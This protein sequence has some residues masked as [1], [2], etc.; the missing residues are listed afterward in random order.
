MRYEIRLAGSGGQ[1]VIMAGLILAEAG[2][3]EGYH[4][5]QTQNYGP[6]VRGGTSIS[7]VILSDA[8]VD[9]PKTLGLDMLLAFDQR[10]CDEN[11]HDMKPEGLVLVDADLVEKVFWGKVVR[12]PFARWSQKKYKEQKFANVLA[13]GALASFCPWFSTGSLRKAIV[14]RVP[15][16]TV[17]SNLAALQE[18]NKLA[19]GL[20]KSLTFQEI[21][22]S[23]EV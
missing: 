12:V 19:N 17:Q 10:A 15:P 3:F 22:G 11:L 6:E 1:G 2:I 20:K 18:G 7:E 9:Y 21:E 16:G 13:L 4:V 5:A 14:K 23:V 8:G